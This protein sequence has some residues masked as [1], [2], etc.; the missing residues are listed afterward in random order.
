MQMEAQNHPQ[1]LLAHGWA[2]TTRAWRGAG[3]LGQEVQ[4]CSTFIS[5]ISSWL[6]NK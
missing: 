1:Q 3:L 4:V 2:V 6:M 5:S